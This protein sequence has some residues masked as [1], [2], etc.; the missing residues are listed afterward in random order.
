VA[1]IK[2]HLRVQL[3]V[4]EVG[5]G[6]RI[7]E[8]V[9]SGQ[10]VRCLRPVF[11]QV[12]LVCAV[13]LM[14]RSQHRVSLGGIQQR[15]VLGP[16]TGAVLAPE[17]LG[18]AFLALEGDVVADPG[19]CELLVLALLMS[20]GSVF[21]L[22]LGFLPERL[23]AEQVGGAGAGLLGEVV[24]LGHAERIAGDAVLFGGGEAGRGL[25]GALAL[26]VVQ[27][28][29]LAL[30]VELLEVVLALRLDSHV[31]VNIRSRVQEARGRA[32][33]A[34]GGVQRLRGLHGVLG[35]AEADGDGVDAL[36][37]EGHELLRSEW[38]LS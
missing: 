23:L 12:F 34:Q 33:T 29:H 11:V 37:L 1:V 14:R 9:F 28:Q 4:Q 8:T 36:G 7:L 30:L 18:C 27:V 16:P 20:L 19:H 3:L 31:T 2:Q 15:L 10:S 21:E 22:V 5:L 17:H 25:G 13:I 24:I 32:G 6:R 26:V 38:L 35:D